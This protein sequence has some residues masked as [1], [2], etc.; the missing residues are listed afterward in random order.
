LIKGEIIAVGTELLLGQIANT[1]AQYISKK[2]AEIGVPIYYHVTVGDNEDRLKKAIIQAQKRSNLIMFTGGLGPTRDDLTKEAAAA[3]FNRK[4]VLDQQT[5]YKIIQ[6]FNQRQI[7]M[8]NNNKKQAMVM[9]GCTVFPNDHGLAAGIGV[10]QDG[11]YYIFL[12][13]PPSEMKPM[14][15]NSAIPWIQQ[16][17]QGNIFYSTVMRFIGIGESSLE[18]RVIDLI[19]AQKNPTIAPLANDG[20]VTLRLTAKAMTMEEGL[21]LIKPVEEEIHRR[22]ESFHYANGEEEIEYVVFHLLERERLTLS[23]SESCTGGLVGSQITK[24][25]G[26]SN[27]YSGGVICYSNDIKSRVLHV[28]HEVLNE[29]GAVSQETAKLLSDETLKL[30]NTDL[31]V[32]ITG[33]AG[34]EPVEDKPVGL[35]YIGIS[36]RG[37]E[38]IVK[39]V[40]LSGS[41][42]AIQTRAAKY[43]FY[44]LWEKL[45]GNVLSLK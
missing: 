39:E 7:I 15:L 29:K 45:N 35:I 24:I 37:K 27:V 18:E 38:T 3:V 22:L 12:P 13:G 26:S 1:N 41:R 6:F 16:I 4:L 19:E 36:E 23:V 9:E 8:T 14:L 28:P 44:F 17:H 40:H 32:S 25:P 5:F 31:A 21:K 34:P 43:A 20:E 30:F 42:Q 10:E 2:M 11:I 33:I